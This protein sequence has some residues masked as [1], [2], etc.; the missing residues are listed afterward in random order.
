M[1]LFSCDITAKC[2]TEMLPVCYYNVLPADFDS[3]QKS[4][5]LLC[6][7][8]DIISGYCHISTCMSDYEDSV[9]YRLHEHIVFAEQ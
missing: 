8:F 2:Q 3:V 6:E 9:S 7:A 1:M 5:F 4:D